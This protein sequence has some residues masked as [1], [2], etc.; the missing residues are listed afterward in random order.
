MIVDI[1]NI[2]VI[3]RRNEIINAVYH[4]HDYFLNF[5]WLIFFQIIGA[6]ITCART[7]AKTVAHSK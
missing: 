2:S 3:L 1:F 4:S 6:N 7:L 5:D